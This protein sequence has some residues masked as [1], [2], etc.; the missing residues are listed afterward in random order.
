MSTLDL[1]DENT[2]RATDSCDC[3]SCA[4]C[5]YCDGQ[6]VLP[7]RHPEIPGPPEMLPCDQCSGSGKAS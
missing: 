7:E 5:P 2:C 4:P 3:P 1:S 6:G